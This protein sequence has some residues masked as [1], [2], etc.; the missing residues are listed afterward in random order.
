M[1]FSEEE[2]NQSLEFVV[3]LGIFEELLHRNDLETLGNLFFEEH[4]LNVFN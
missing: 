2:T 1:F 4:D 3:L